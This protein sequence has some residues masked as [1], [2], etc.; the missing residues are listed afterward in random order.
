[1]LGRA[2]RTTSTG[3]H[4]RRF[5][6][7]GAGFCAG[8]QQVQVWAQDLSVRTAI[9]NSCPEGHHSCEV[10]INRCGQYGISNGAGLAA[11]LVWAYVCHISVV[12]IVASNSGGAGD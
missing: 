3:H 12:T 9:T 2:K 4:D 5:P 1:M 7:A 10:A 6:L 8:G 11:L